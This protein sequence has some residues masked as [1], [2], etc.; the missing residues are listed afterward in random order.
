M[1]KNILTL[2][3]RNNPC[4]NMVHLQITRYLGEE[5]DPHLDTTS[6][7]VVVESGKIS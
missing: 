6:L 7:Q 5:A 2:T 3:L 4:R 1:G